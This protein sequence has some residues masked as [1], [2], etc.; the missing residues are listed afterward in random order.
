M[1]HQE[2]IWILTPQSPLSWVSESF[3]GYLPLPFSLNESLQISTL[4]FSSWLISML[5]RLWS[6]ILMWKVFFLFKI[7][8]F[9]MKNLTD[10]CKMVESNKELSLNPQESY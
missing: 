3:T 1:L 6:R 9:I 5:Y 7:Y 2:I 4:L 10:F 8:I